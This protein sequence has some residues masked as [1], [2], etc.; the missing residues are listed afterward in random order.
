MLLLCQ[1]AI[2]S[3]EILCHFPVLRGAPYPADAATYLSM[4]K[5]PFAINQ[6]LQAYRLWL[7]LMENFAPAT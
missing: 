3:K 6:H 4:A 5:I 2:F 7:F 1:S